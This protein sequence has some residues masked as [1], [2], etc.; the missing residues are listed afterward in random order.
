MALYASPGTD[1]VVGENTYQTYTY[2]GVVGTWMITNSKE[3]I[4][5]RTTFPG[6]ESGER[7]YY[8][9]LENAATAC[10]SGW[11][12]P[13]LEDWEK[14]KHYY[15]YAPESLKAEEAARHE[16]GGLPQASPGSYGANWDVASYYASTDTSIIFQFWGGYGQRALGSGNVVSVRCIKE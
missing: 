12:V 2:P 3:G 7:G 10:P 8:Y 5:N 14:L 4:Y 13:T 11:R 6:K 1:L 9:T 15:Y 16:K